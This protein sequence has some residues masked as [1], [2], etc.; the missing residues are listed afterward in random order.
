MSWSHHQ[1]DQ[2]LQTVPDSE[3]PEGSMGYPLE[4]VGVFG[5]STS[6]Y[7]NPQYPLT[8]LVAT[9]IKTLSITSA[10]LYPC[11]AFVQ[12]GVIPSAPLNPTVGFT[13]QSLELFRVLH[14][15]CPRLLQQA[16]VKTLSDLQLVSL[17]F[18]E[19][20][21]INSRCVPLGPVPE[22]SY[23]AILHCL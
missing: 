18:I 14:L 3:L 19:T 15:R 10:D 2:I 6:S 11:T 7:V 16:Y 21:Y 1:G 4:V 8:H 22:I 20:T 9:E 17:I 13:V 12:Q 23:P 5:R